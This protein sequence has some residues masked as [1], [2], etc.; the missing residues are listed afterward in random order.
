M[1]SNSKKTKE[2]EEL[3]SSIH[4]MGFWNVSATATEQL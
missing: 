3:L 4:E 2:W 1:L